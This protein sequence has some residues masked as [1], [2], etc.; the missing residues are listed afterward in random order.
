MLWPEPR[1]EKR[2]ATPAGYLE[3]GQDADQNDSPWS[4]SLLMAKHD[5][6]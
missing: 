2:V 5:L 6:R 4:Q 1:I 3:Q